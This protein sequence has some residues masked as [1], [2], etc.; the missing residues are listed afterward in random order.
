MLGGAWIAALLSCTPNVSERDIRG[1]ELPAVLAGVDDPSVLF[2]DARAP[3]RYRVSR[4]PGAI[5]VS[6]VEI[7]L[8]ASRLTRLE[9]AERLIVYGQNPG[10]PRASGLTLRLLEA[11]YS[12]VELFRGGIEAWTN[13]GRT[14]ESGEPS[15]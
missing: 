3:S 8:E 7:D 11:G 9:A 6:I 14:L 12:G 13:A 15:D 5:S 1:V 4:L 2:V 10:D